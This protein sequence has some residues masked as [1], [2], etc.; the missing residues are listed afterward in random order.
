MFLPLHDGA[1]MRYLRAPI[2]NYSLIALNVLVFL[3]MSAGL[4]G[5][6]ERID[7]AFGAIPAVLFNNAALAKGVAVVPEFLTPLTSLF[8]HGGFAHIAGNMLFLWVFGDNVEDSM[9]SARYLAFYLGCGVCGGLLYA[10]VDP[11][12]Q[13]PLIGAS[14]AISGVVMAYMMLYPRIRVLGLVLNVLPLRVPAFWC[15][16]AWIFLQ[17]VSAL[18]NEHSDVG[19]W[20]HVGGIACGALLTPFLHRAE[21]PLFSA[22]EA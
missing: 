10:A 3:A 11:T 9:G 7:L 1:P 8:V 22:R 14:G 15:L 16:G 17:I 18:A 21:T 20:A 4:F 5:D 6:E 2:V 13:S 12:S 19:F